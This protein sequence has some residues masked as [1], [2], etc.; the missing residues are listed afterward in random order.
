MVKTL[1][2]QAGGVLVWELK[3]HV[4]HGQN[5]KTYSRGNIVTDTIKALK[6]SPS[7]KILKYSDE[8]EVASVLIRE[9]EV[10]WQDSAVW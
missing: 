2:S 7:K 9:R 10:S 8:K 1:P 4:P 3:S 5:P 6:W